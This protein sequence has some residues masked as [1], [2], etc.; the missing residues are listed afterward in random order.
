MGNNRKSDRERDGLRGPV[1]T[2]AEFLGDEV[3]SMCEAEYGRDGRLLVW[4]G[5][6]SGGT[7]V[8]R[9]YSYDGTGR[10]IDITSGG[11]DMTDEFH[12]D[13]QG[14]KTMVRTVPPKTRP[15]KG[16]DGHW[17]L[18]GSHR[19]RRVF[20]WRGDDYNSLQRE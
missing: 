2:C 5:R 7:R 8:E 14:R 18:I 12:F 9:I 17:D 3:E 6:I 11:A 1:K 10:L 15:A 19:G 16:W 13:E 4:R 20:D